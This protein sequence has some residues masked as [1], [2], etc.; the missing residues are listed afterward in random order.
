M[1]A[2]D[3]IGVGRDMGSAPIQLAA[4]LRTQLS[5]R[6]AIETGTYLGDGARRLAD[7]FD[8]VVT[9]ELSDDY[10]RRASAAL[11]E[12]ASVRVIRGDS[13]LELDGL[14]D[15][16]V[17]TFYFLDGHWSGGD[18][19]GEKSECPVLEEIAAIGKGH[20]DDC[21]VVDDARLFAAAPPPPHDPAAWPTLTEVFD[22]IHRARPGHHVTMLRD[23]VIATPA[24]VKHSVDRYAWGE[25]DLDRVHEGSEG[26][27]TRLRSRLHRKG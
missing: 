6:R 20:Q 17:P 18:T 24:R 23:Q 19:A 26:P 12:L 1:D 22:A 13:R 15:E 21:L 7:I 4:E 16:R 5:L 27:F 2:A 11:S 8:N 10:S 25:L 14:T 3:Q 9:I